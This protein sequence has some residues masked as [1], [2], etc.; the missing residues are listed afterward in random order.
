MII[1]IESDL[2]TFK[3]VAFGKGLN[4]LLADKAPA[5]GAKK[6]RN[7]AGKS[8]LVEIINFL[9]GSKADPDSLPR[10][11]A[12]IDST[13]Y[14]AFQIGEAMI[15][16][17]RSGRDPGKI[18][19]DQEDAILIGLKAKRTKGGP[20]HV[21]NEEWKACLGREFFA[22]TPDGSAVGKEK[23]SPTFRSLI[24]Y[25]LRRRLG[26]TSAEAHST[27][28]QTWD[29]Q[30]NL[31]YL[32]GLDWTIPSELQGVRQ[33]ERALLE[34]KKA[35]SDGPIGDL[36][37]ATA[38]IRPKIV[39]AEEA[40][41]GLKDRIS[42][43]RVLETYQQW[44]DEAVALRTGM[45]AIERNAVLLKQNLAHVEAAIAEEKSPQESEIARMYAAA[46]VQL[47][48]TAI[49]RF[50]DVRS[51]H[52]SV[53]ANRKLRLQAEADGL[54]DQIRQGAELSQA[55]DH[56]RS[57]VLRELDGFGAF[58]DFMDLQARLAK[59][60]AEAASL[61]KRFE[62]ATILEGSS[63]QLELDR[64]NLKRRLQED[65]Q[66]RQW[67]I[68][69]AIRIVGRAIE[70]LYQDRTGEFVVRATDGGPSF[71]IKIQGDR[72]GGISQMEIFCLDLALLMIGQEDR[73]GPNFLVHDSHLYDGVDERQVARA[74]MLGHMTTELLE[75]QY[76]VTMNSDVFDRLPFPDDF[77]R[78]A[79]VLETRL[80]DDGADGGL[81]G[82]RFD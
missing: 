44:S 25:F 32:L 39:L 5:S 7:S 27:K 20:W 4:V 37:G 49:R 24:G 43:F 9:M 77:D 16:V 3:N 82:I 75:G 2:P 40:I 66:A 55:F 76:I 62:A 46:G 36:V 42:Q 73:R 64:V 69:R 81:F 26:F 34:M 50:E 74:L 65:H 61:R 63:T 48:G 8:S 12:L 38:D 13:F 19:I 68:D 31:S 54:R 18:L 17:A 14:G 70:F 56:R 11:T 51:F 33:A 71:D 72:G 52:A 15:Q 21:S 60:E 45:L 23:F 6:T 22:L 80:S 78:D 58:A 35:A 47:P 53:L 67:R 10:N 30:V 29:W 79:I 28:Q 1:S 41:S 57:E 59:A